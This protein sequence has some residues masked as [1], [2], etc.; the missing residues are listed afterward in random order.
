[1]INDKIDEFLQDLFHISFD[2]F[3]VIHRFDW[4]NQQVIFETRKTK[5]NQI[6]TKYYF[7]LDH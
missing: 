3:E 7:L 6:K 2:W 4:L 5:F 1:M